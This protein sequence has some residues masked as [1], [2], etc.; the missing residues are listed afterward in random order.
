MPVE[1]LAGESLSLQRR[2]ASRCTA[3]AA[4]EAGAVGTNPVVRVGG[5]RG[6]R[7]LHLSAAAA[8]VAARQA[9]IGAVPDLPHWL[10]RPVS[11]RRDASLALATAAVVKAIAAFCAPAPMYD[12]GLPGRCVHDP[13]GT[14]IAVIVLVALAE[15]CILAAPHVVLRLGSLLLDLGDRAVG[16]VVRASVDVEVVAPPHAA[17]SPANNA[18]IP[19]RYMACIPRPREQFVRRAVHRPAWQPV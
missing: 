3:S 18:D 12:A 6:S 19:A 15:V 8:A 11:S 16:I 10:G 2:Q 1:L 14:A 13:I 9:E 5:Q 4:I 7:R 17:H